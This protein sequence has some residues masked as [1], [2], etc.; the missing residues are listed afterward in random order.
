[1][2]HEITTA[3]LNTLKEALEAVDIACMQC[4]HEDDREDGLPEVIRDFV[5][6]ANHIKS[7]LTV[8]VDKQD[9]VASTFAKFQH[10]VVL[11][12][13]IDAELDAAF[14]DCCKLIGC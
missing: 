14:H 8:D 10:K 7:I 5:N 1:M 9:Y 12:E 11:N 4:L 2:K 3:T 6:L 13:F